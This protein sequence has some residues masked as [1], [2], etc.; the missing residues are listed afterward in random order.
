MNKLCLLLLLTLIFTSCAK[1]DDS[2]VSL[3]VSSISPETGSL[4][5]AVTITGTGFSTTLA[6]NVVTINNKPAKVTAAT[7]TSLTVT[8]P[9]RAGSGKFIV[10]TKGKTTESPAFNYETT[11]IVSTLAGGTRGFADGTGT[12]AHFREI[13][14]I[15]VAPDGSLYAADKENNRIRKITPDGVV[16]TFVGGTRGHS[17]GIGTAAQLNLPSGIVLG[18]NGIFYVCDDHKIR[19]I[20]ADGEVMTLAG[21]SWGY[22][23][24]LGPTA[25][26]RGLYNIA[27]A[28]NGN[29]FVTDYHNNRIRKIAPDGT[30]STFAG[31]ESGYEDGTGTQA[32][33]S[34]PMGITAGADGNL[35]VTDGSNRIRKITPE[36]VVTTFSSIE[37]GYADGDL[38]A[39]RFFYP[40]NVVV[41]SDGTMYVSDM[42]NHKIRQI[43]PEGKVTTL[44]GGSQGDLDGTGTQAKFYMPAALALAADSILYVSEYGNFKIRKI[45]LR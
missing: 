44:A 25:D 35:F 40:L 33:F 19:T 39:A 43:S 13:R 16:T 1:E 10:K 17:D 7:H 23:D 21:R 27:R 32:R 20:T 30:V 3:T 36:G 18:P 38:G 28:P 31:N 4:G 45:I 5:T 8:I 34:S 12:N 15:A 2:P 11:A 14:Q 22:A 9:V 37:V 26:F 29:L 41:A 6:E 24:G 42:L